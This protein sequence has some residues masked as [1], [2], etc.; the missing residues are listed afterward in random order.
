MKSLKI[1]I[2]TMKKKFKNWIEYISVA[3]LCCNQF[4][5]ILSILNFNKTNLQKTVMGSKYDLLFKVKSIVDHLWNVFG[6]IITP[7]TMVAVN[8]VIIVFKDRHKLK[9]Y[10]L[11]QPTKWGYTLWSLTDVSGINDPN[12]P[13]P[14]KQVINGVD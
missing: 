11:K 4:Q 13:P 6:A 12:V 9:C 5:Q 7:K 2:F 1:Q 8:K 10:R 3:N 14:G